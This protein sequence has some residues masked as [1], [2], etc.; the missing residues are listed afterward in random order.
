MSETEI[1]NS[2]LGFDPQQMH[3]DI[4][5]YANLLEADIIGTRDN[6]VVSPEAKRAGV[7]EGTTNITRKTAIQRLGEMSE[8]QKQDLALDMFINVTGAYGSFND[9]F[10]EDGTLN[11]DTFMIAWET[12][13]S[14]ALAYGPQGLKLE[15]DYVNILLQEDEESSDLELDSLMKVAQTKQVNQ[16]GDAAY[17]ATVLDESLGTL[18]G[19]RPT[20]LDERKFMDFLTTTFAERPALP[21]NLAA[22]EFVKTEYAEQYGQVD[23]RRRMRGFLDAVRNA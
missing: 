13:F 1:P 4:N 20:P 22:D 6:M 9:I 12:T 16:L 5:Q 2:Q 8:L 17:F 21:V 7:D 11:M 15:T 18:L 10:N 19:R 3:A 14:R 23:Q